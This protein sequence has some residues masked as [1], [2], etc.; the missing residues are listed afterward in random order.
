M[1]FVTTPESL[2]NADRIKNGEPKVAADHVARIAELE[3]E[4]ARLRPPHNQRR[5]SMKTET[6][7]VKACEVI[8]GDKISGDFV[9]KVLPD[10]CVSLVYMSGL[11]HAARIPN[12]WNLT[13]TRPLPDPCPR[14]RMTYGLMANT[15]SGA[16]VEIGGETVADMTV[17]RQ[18]AFWERIQK[19]W[20]ESEATR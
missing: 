15:T 11:R 2:A 8:A 1:T 9:T 18:Q 4:N 10:G 12:E 6:I 5:R 14:G 19:L 13:V 20:N 7:T 3:A 17:G 16:N